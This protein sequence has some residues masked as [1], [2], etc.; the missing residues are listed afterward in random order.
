MKRKKMA[1]DREARRFVAIFAGIT[2]LLGRESV[3]LGWVGTIL[4]VWCLYFFR[5][6]ERILPLDDGKTLISPADGRIVEIG[7]YAP[8]EELDL[9]TA[10]LQRVSIFMSV[11]SVH[12]NRAPIAGTI[13]RVVY[14]P[15]KFFNAT[16]NKASAHNEREVVSIRTAHGPLVYVRIAGLIARRIRRDIREGNVV[17][18]G[19][20]VGLIRFGSRVDV[21]LPPQA[22]LAVEEGQ[23]MI[24]GETIIARFPGEAHVV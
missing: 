6:P 2:F 1:F 11:F 4:T 5:D 24:A 7:F 13:E 19:Q 12:V 9:G 10:L 21:Y 23:T 22:V 15:G 18:L 14:I 20:R 17:A 8:P 3:H 16:L